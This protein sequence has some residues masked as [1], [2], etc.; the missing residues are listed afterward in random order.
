MSNTVLDELVIRLGLDTTQ[1]QANA[2]K[3]LG[4][5][6]QLEQKNIAVGKS[7]AQTGKTASSSLSTLRREALGLLGLVSGGR[8]LAQVLQTLTP[9]TNQHANNTTH[10]TVNFAKGL[11]KPQPLQ[12]RLPPL[13]QLPSF[14]THSFAKNLSNNT[15]L[16]SVIVNPSSTST[17]NAAHVRSATRSNAA[18]VSSKPVI[19]SG[20]AVNTMLFTNKPFHQPSTYSLQ[21]APKHVGHSGFSPN[22]QR[23]AAAGS[24]RVST[25]TPTVIVPGGLGS[26]ASTQTRLRV[27]GLLPNSQ[28]KNNYSTKNVFSTLR[29]NAL[30]TP[31]AEQPRRH[32]NTVQ[33]SVRPLFFARVERATRGL[34]GKRSTL[35][36]ASAVLPQARLR[37]LNNQFVA[38]P[39]VVPTA[40]LLH[41]ASLPTLPRASAPAPS[42]QITYIGPVTISVPT[43]N[44]QAIAEALR[45]IGAHTNH[46][47]ASLA[48]RGAV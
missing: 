4:T 19:A 13:K 26:S 2:H 7:L 35:V 46:T 9:S 47:L 28:H 8:G 23:I 22:R 12:A 24:L 10:K 3:A 21:H 11:K 33:H 30:H 16:A 41:L 5:L 34:A 32:R 27:G 17:A 43:G 18:Q 40:Q 6:D 42:A 1:M 15:A 38:Q 37:G 36:P 25:P 20:A 39:S 14:Y 31:L 45:A 48:T 29:H 44:P